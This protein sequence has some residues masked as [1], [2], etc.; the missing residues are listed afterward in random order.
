MRRLSRKKKNPS[1]YNVVGSSS[2][3]REDDRSFLCFS[4]SSQSFFLLLLDAFQAEL[5]THAHTH[6]LTH[7]RAH[8]HTHSPNRHMILWDGP[9][10]RPHTVLIK[11]AGSSSSSS[12][13]GQLRPH[14][15]AQTAASCELLTSFLRL[16][17]RGIPR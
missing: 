7:T 13:V 8:T 6:A 3:L 17:W 11:T 4:F 16:W 12:S 5:H 15:R 1:F 14:A 10:T 9:A 2:L